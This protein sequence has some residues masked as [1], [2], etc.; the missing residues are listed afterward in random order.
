MNHLV[1]SSMVN[2]IQNNLAESRSI[3][4]GYGNV[5]FNL[6]IVVVI[7]G[8]ALTFL[9]VQYHHAKTIVQPVSIPKREYI[10]NNTIRNSIEL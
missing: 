9:V 1:D 4:T 2:R 6:F 3:R 10:W 7:V 8:G 5:L